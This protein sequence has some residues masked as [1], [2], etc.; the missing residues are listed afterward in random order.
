M[1][2]LLAYPKSRYARYR[3]PVAD[4]VNLLAF[5]RRSLRM[6]RRRWWI[7][8]LTL[9]L[10]T[11]VSVYY[12]KTQPDIYMASSRLSVA[13]KVAFSQRAGDRAIITEERQNYIQAQLEYMKGPAL[14][15]RVEEKMQDARNPDGTL[16][17]KNLSV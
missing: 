6:F 1:P 9:A 11:G 3:A 17:D 4:R 14:L 15:S 5:L 8:L 12:A 7:V 13:P 2:K 10:G 16:P